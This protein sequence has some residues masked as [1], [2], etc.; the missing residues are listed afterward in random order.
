MIEI[1]EAMKIAKDF[2]DNYGGKKE[3]FHLE[4]AYLNKEENTWK[5]TYSFFQKNHPL[6]ALQEL[7]GIEGRRVYRTIEIDNKNG[8]VVG[9]KAGFGSNL[10]EIV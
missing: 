6:N 3:G 10:G 4:E 7:A 5:V 9:M 8:E 2:I 1:K